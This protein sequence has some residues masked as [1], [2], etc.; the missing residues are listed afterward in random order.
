[1]V[2]EQGLLDLMIASGVHNNHAAMDDD[3]ASCG[4]FAHVTGQLRRRA[5]VATNQAI[6]P[7]LRHVV[8]LAAIQDHHEGEIASVQ[9]GP[10]KTSLDGVIAGIQRAL[11]SVTRAD[12]A[13]GGGSQ[14]T[15]LSPLA[16]ARKL[17]PRRVTE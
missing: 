2:I 13:L 9:Q 3:I 16:S 10:T 15:R 1:M 7:L 4:N 17:W 11:A 6:L 8:A 12:G 14:Y 5:L